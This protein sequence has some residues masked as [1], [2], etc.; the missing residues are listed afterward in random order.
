[1]IFFGYMLKGEFNAKLKTIQPVLNSFILITCINSPPSYHSFI[2]IIVK[3]T[4]MHEHE[5][6]F[7]HFHK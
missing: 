2:I 3:L 1:M 6:K 4:Y 7:F 5:F